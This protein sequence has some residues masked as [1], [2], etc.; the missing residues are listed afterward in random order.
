MGRNLT[1]AWNDIHAICKA[2]D[3]D[4]KQLYEKAKMIL[5][6][7]RRVC[8]STMGRADAVAEELCYYCSSDLDGA[9]IYLE[10]FVPEVEKQRFESRIMTLFETRWMVELVDTAMLC[11]KEF[12]NG[13]EQHFEILSKC[14]LSRFRYTEGEMLELLNMERSRFYDR[15]REAVMV[16]GLSLWGEAISKLKGFLNNT[17]EDLEVIP[18]E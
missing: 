12:P 6:V 16:F 9:L 15:K 5:Q 1:S 4:E 14:Y 8:W 11:V 13:G 7:Y 18:Y 10:E 2:R 3:I 17:N